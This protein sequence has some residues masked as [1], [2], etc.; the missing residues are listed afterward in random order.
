MILLET[1]TLLPLEDEREVISLMCSYLA[2][3]FIGPIDYVRVPLTPE[4]EIELRSI[5]CCRTPITWPNAVRLFL[6]SLV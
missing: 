2:L 4:D 5:D 3:C 6:G 1:T